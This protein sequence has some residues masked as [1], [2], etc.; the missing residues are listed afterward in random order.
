MKS[1]N[2]PM[3]T[4]DAGFARY[5]EEI[6]QFPILTEVEE[7]ALARSWYYDQDVIAAQ[8]LVTSHLRLVAKLAQQYKGYGLSMTDI[9]SEGNVGLMIAVKKFDPNKGFRLA[10]YA[11]WWIK[12]MI[13]DYILKSWSLVK[14]GTSA[15]HK[16]LFF[17]LRKIKNKLT[18]ANNGRPPFNEIELIAK[19]LEVPQ[20]DVREMNERF[21]LQESSLNEYVNE[22]GGD[23]L[24]NTITDN[25]D[26]THEDAIFE[27]QEYNIKRNRFNN[28]LEKLNERERDILSK[29]KLSETPETLESLS[30][31]Y[32]VSTERIRQIEEQAINK[33]KKLVLA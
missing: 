2:V 5:L 23:E 14:I 4:Q 31:K 19:E 3:L 33:V 12:A 24:I 1:Y 22:D 6:K 7:L 20:A 29:R 13:Q 28:A 8:K 26:G 32:L 11:M 30:K 10:T 9:I 21:T 25:T 17:N 16:K 27:A 15:T 18:Q